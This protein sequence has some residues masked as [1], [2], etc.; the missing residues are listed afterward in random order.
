MS[1]RTPSS[2]GITAFTQGDSG[3]SESGSLVLT[4]APAAKRGCGRPRL[5]LSEE[6]RLERK[7][8]QDRRSQAKRKAR[9]KTQQTATVAAHAAALTELEAARAER[10][11]L[12]QQG[13]AL[14]LLL[15]GKDEAI[16]VL[17]Q[18][19][20][21]NSNDS[22]AGVC[23]DP[24]DTVVRAAAELNRLGVV[25]RAQRVCEL[26]F[27]DPAMARLQLEMKPTEAFGNRQKQLEPCAAAVAARMLP[28]DVMPAF[29][30]AAQH[31][32]LVAMICSRSWEGF[33]ADWQDEGLL[34]K[35][36]LAAHGAAGDDRIL[37]RIKPVQVRGAC[38][39]VC[40]CVCVWWWWWWRGGPAEPSAALWDH[41][42][43]SH[44][45]PLREI[46]IP[47]PQLA[48]RVHARTHP[49]PRCGGQ[50]HHA[51]PPGV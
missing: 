11:H 34:F 24:N 35:S 9:I 7:R 20:P 29:T 26:V 3:G 28:P 42:W 37:D 41:L 14:H 2:T 47:P 38:D 10:E 31:P 40:V 39:A 25:E 33:V 13:S 30:A 48:T 5:N 12:A 18:A 45:P 43:A 16:V 36:V 21:S 22:S 8:E 17:Q 27:A 32:V 44:P 50:R 46:T 1:Q 15:E 19:A 49:L 51:R 6:E 23:Q 4:A